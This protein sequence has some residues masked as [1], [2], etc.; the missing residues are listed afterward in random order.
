[1]SDR[2]LFDVIRGFVHRRLVLPLVVVAMLTTGGLVAWR[3]SA[4]EREHEIIAWGI[5]N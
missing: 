2:A 1:M 4:L 3:I 5:D